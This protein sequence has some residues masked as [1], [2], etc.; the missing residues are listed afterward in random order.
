MFLANLIV[1]TLAAVMIGLL[2]CWGLDL[3]A[4]IRRRRAETRT[5]PDP[6]DGRASA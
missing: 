2:V 4:E 6:T 3:R 1:Y 5:K